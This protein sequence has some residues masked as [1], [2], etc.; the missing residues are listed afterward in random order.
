[1][2]RS[3]RD[4]LA[5]RAEDIVSA[6]RPVPVDLYCEIVGEST[7][8]NGRWLVLDGYPRNSEQYQGLPAVCHAAAVWYPLIFGVFLAVD[9]SELHRRMGV[10]R[11]SDDTSPE[12]VARRL[13]LYAENASGL[14]S[15]FRSGGRLLTVS[16]TMATANIVDTI[17]KFVSETSRVASVDP[18]LQ[19]SDP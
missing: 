19:R 4:L 7:R 1:M 13:E 8:G 12:L 15:R 14:Q 18:L 6:G 10:R 3:R 5:K 17:L 11:R 2:R 9:D 16:G